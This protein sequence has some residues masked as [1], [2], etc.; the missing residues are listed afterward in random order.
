MHRFSVNPYLI[1]NSRV[2]GDGQVVWK[3]TKGQLTDSSKT[4]MANGG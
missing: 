2:K 1:K 4:K 3:H